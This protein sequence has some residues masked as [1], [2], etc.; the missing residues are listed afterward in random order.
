MRTT[1]T[2]TTA[3][4][5]DSSIGQRWQAPWP[6]PDHATVKLEHRV[7]YRQVKYC[8]R[9]GKWRYEARWHSPLSKA[10]IITYPCWCLERIRPGHGYGETAAPRVAQTWVA[11]RWLPTR[12]V[13]YW[14]KLANQHPTVTTLELVRAA[15]P[16]ATVKYFPGNFPQGAHDGRTR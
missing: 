13:R 5:K 10:A 11:G 8:W 1:L 6:I 7:G 3:A 9:A 14:T 2:L 4:G 15:Q 12:Q 16:A